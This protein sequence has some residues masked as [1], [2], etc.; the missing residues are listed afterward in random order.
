MTDIKLTNKLMAPSNLTNYTNI[1]V[2]LFVMDFCMKNETHRWIE[3]ELV[4]NEKS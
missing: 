1:Y 3:I 2:S 4:K